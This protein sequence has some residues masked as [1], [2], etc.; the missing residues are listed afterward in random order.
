MIK[1]I[2]TNSEGLIT[3]EPTCDCEILNIKDESISSPLKGGIIING[4]YG[5]NN[6]NI[7]Y[8]FN[9]IKIKNLLI[10]DYSHPAINIKS[11]KSLVEIDNIELKQTVR[12]AEFNGGSKGLALTS[13]VDAIQGLTT[14][15]K[16]LHVKNP[17]A[18]FLYMQNPY[19]YDIKE[20]ICDGAFYNEDGS[21]ATINKSG[22][23]LMKWKHFGN[24]EG[25]KYKIG[26][27]II[28]NTNT[29]E[30]LKTPDG[31]DAGL[32]RNGF[33]FEANDTINVDINHLDIDIP[34]TLLDANF[35]IKEATIR[36]AFGG[37]RTRIENANIKKL[38]IIDTCIDIMDTNI[39]SLTLINSELRVNGNCD[40]DTI[41]EDEKSKINVIK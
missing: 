38:T 16:K 24:G 25:R 26:S 27:I 18:S 7:K 22:V 2:N 20:I 36:N 39:K 9:K 13:D 1:K 29:S 12:V 32:Y 3:Y 21:D 6:L 8:H 34:F 23:A 14:K 35:N 15:I 31:Q 10:E 5:D 37:T 17:R 40:I 33:R 30:K 28:K 4:Q 41:I 19:G 11:I